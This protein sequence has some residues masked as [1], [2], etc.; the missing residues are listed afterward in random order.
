MSSYVVEVVD[1]QRASGGLEESVVAA[2]RAA[3]AHQGAAANASLTILLADDD[4]LQALNR[5]FLGYDAPTD[6][7]SFPSGE[8]VPGAEGYLGD[9]AISLPTA[10]HQARAA[11]HELAAEL[12]LLT[13]HAVLH[14]LG[15]DHAA[16]EEKE[17]MWTAQGE[18]LAQLGPD[19]RPAEGVS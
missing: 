14:L 4:R 7:L 3:L 19:L 15:H 12:Q 18:I 5:D 8:S 9:I 17:A 13:V 2:A 16:A 10:A 6:V 11:G 1:E